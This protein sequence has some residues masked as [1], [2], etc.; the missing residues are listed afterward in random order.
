MADEDELTV[1][2]DEGKSSANKLIIIIA[3]ALLAIGALAIGAYF[4][5]GGDDAGQPVAAA[6]QQQRVQSIYYKLEKPFVVNIRS[7]GRQR[8]MQINVSIKGKD[9]QAMAMIS[10]H[11][12]VIKNDL[13]QLFSSQEVQV[14]QTKEGLEKLNQD[15]TKTVQS[16]LQKEIGSPGI[17]QVLFEN[18]V[19]Q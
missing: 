4:F 16:F 18:F 12:P 15:A 11:E 14:L 2:D 6:E 8:H 1:A 7:S 10:K 9:P 5:I 3:A 13:N 19:M 17:D